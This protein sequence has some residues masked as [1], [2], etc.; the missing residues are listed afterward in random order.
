M[1]GGVYLD[2]RAVGRRRMREAQ[3]LGFLQVEMNSVCISVS[4][5]RLLWSVAVGVAC[6][7]RRTRPQ[8]GRQSG[9]P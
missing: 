3:G 5:E 7:G 8:C 9:M 6:L 1:L 2:R 4:V